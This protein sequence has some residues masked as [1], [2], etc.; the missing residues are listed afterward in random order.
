MNNE[1]ERGLSRLHLPIGRRLST[2]IQYLCLA[3]L[4]IPFVFPFWWMI[5]SSFKS[6]A[7]I[8]TFPP[9]LLP[10]VWD[11][12]NY[13]QAF[14]FQPFAQQ[15]FNSVYIAVLVTVGVMFVSTLSGYAFARIPFPGKSFFFMLLL[16]SVMMPA[17]VTIIP[18]YM[19]MKTLG[20]LDT[21]IPLII[22]PILGPSSIV[23]TF[24]ARQF[25][26]SLPSE[27]E[28]A[29]MIDGLGRWGIYTKIVL[30]IA[31]PCLAPI[32]ILTFLSSWNSFIEPLVY[33]STNSKF[34]LPLALRGYTD[35]FGV[36]LWG[37]QMAATTLATLPVLIVFILAQQQVVE[38]FAQ[39]GI[40]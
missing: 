28:D 16:S 25:F 17:E 35:M 11:F 19:F 23:A 30:P 15:Y 31:R 33:L 12:Q 5:S 39:S 20:V 9:T 8:F 4:A 14:T 37:V 10:Q 24:I 6:Y 32:A 1:L 27:L 13:S 7:E 29:A 2:F 26:L 36:P 18:N 40:K 34:T 3:I 21:H 38:S 22:I